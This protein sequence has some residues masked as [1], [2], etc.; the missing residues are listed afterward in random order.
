MDALLL[1][2]AAPVAVEQ[3][4]FSIISGVFENDAFLHSTEMGEEEESLK[5]LCNN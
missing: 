1:A 4:G 2:K 5:I 3:M